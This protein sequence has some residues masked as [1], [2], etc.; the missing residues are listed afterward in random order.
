[1]MTMRRCYT[2][3]YESSSFDRFTPTLASSSCYADMRHRC[4]QV[5]FA[6]KGEHTIEAIA[7][8]FRP[9]PPPKQ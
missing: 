5:T 9:P 6:F 2:P 4:H 3:L 7:A 8:I 1:M